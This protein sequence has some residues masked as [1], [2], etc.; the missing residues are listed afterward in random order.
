M[1]A[2][3]HE[4]PG[5]L[6]AADL[7]PESEPTPTLDSRPLD[8]PSPEPPPAPTPS[9]K[10]IAAGASV[11]TDEQLLALHR[12]GDA[13]AL[14]TL[15]TRYQDRLY[16]LCFRMV[17]HHE[18]A[19]DLTQECMVRLI[20]GFPG[21]DGKSQLSTWI[22]R[23]A[24]NVCFSKL[25]SEKLRRHASLDAPLAGG[26]SA[27][28]GGVAAFRSPSASGT[29]TFSAAGSRSGSAPSFDGSSDAPPSW[30]AIEDPR[31][32]RVM[33]RVQFRDDRERLRAALTLLD[34][35]TR[36]I[37]VLRDGRDLDYE[38]IAEV[39]GIAVGTVKSR[40]FRAR[41]AL[42]DLVERL[43]RGDPVVL[44]ALA[45]RPQ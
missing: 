44:G 40:L 33:T 45:S 31:E 10:A 27:A 12:A 24:L 15:L 25:R 6:D 22:T 29:G 18:M 5:P 11:Q 4:M 14:A 21:F 26:R 42:R 8:S 16:G 2:Q 20:Q 1:S 13:R 41:S 34:A 3:F 37:L 38:Q 7:P 36:A 28:G 17:N 9:L 23:V 39:F 19:A 35:E 32:Q 30:T 43:E